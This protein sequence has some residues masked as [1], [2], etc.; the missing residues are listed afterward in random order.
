MCIRDSSIK[1][2]QI[3]QFID[4][5]TDLNSIVSAAG[6]HED[7]ERKFA[8][9]REL[10]NGSLKRH[11]S[12]L[13]R[14]ILNDSEWLVPSTLSIA[15]IAI[16]RVLGWLSSGILD[17]IPQDILKSFPKI[18]KLCRAV[19]ENKKIKSWIGKTYPKGYFRGTY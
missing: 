14:L 10:A 5:A 7:I 1:A 3:D 17:G 16:W 18:K 13:E 15:D 6:N 11:L 8:A 12:M 9:R 19:D 2:A 4:F